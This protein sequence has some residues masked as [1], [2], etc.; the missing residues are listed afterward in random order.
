MQ[1]KGHCGRMQN[2][3]PKIQTAQKEVSLLLD[4][5]EGSKVRSGIPLDG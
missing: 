4:Y 2:K 3:N 1:K 5:C